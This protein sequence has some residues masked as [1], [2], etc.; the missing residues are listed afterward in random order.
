MRD[1][2]IDFETLGTGPDA[3]I[4]QVGAC[5]FDR[6]TGEIGATFKRNFD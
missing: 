2:M 4:I 1:C 6:V 5:Y 3:A